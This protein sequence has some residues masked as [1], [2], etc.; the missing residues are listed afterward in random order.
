[1]D[2]QDLPQGRE[3]G[4]AGVVKGY[5]TLMDLAIGLV[6]AIVVT[7]LIIFLW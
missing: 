5:V 6:L 1:V 7:L 2:R 3:D 4:R